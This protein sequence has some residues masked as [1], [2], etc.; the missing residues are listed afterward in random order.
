M[1]AV[2]MMVLM[3]LITMVLMMGLVVATNDSDDKILNFHGL[4]IGL[5][6]TALYTRSR[7]WV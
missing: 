2:V 6:T 3:V 4:V 7:G 5:N 1:D